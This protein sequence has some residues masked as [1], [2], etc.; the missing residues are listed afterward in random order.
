MNHYLNKDSGFGVSQRMEKARLLRNQE[1]QLTNTLKQFN[2]VRAVKVHLAIPRESSFIKNRRKPSASVLLNLYSRGS[3]SEEQ[4]DAMVDLVSGSIPNLN[5]NKVTIT[6][7]YGRLYHSGSMSQTQR[8]SSKELEVI[9]E[10]REDIK[11]RIEEILMPIV[12]LGAYTVQVNVD[13]DFTKTEQTLQTFNPDLPAVRSERTIDDNRTNGQAS[14]IPGALS[15]QPPGDATIPTDAT[16]ATGDNANQNN[17]A[18]NRRVEAE[19]N[20]DLDT[21]ISHIM[22]QVGVVKRISV[23]VGLDYIDDVNNAGQK[24]ARAQTELAR[25][26][27]LIQAAV[28]FT[29]QRGDIVSVESFPFI[30]GET[31]PEPEPLPFYEQ[32]LFQTWFKPFLGLIAFL[33]LIF[34]VLRPTMKKLSTVHVAQTPLNAEA[35]DELDL[36]GLQNASNELDDSVVLSGHDSLELPPPSVGEVKK[37]E[38]AKG[39]V[40]NNPTLVAQLVKSWIDEDG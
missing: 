7:Q 34:A 15:N 16:A 18:S 26:Q 2:G 11:S 10:R 31:L 9:R 40:G 32:E 27:N 39:V 6:D 37:L 12:G 19:R 20:F 1:L 23:S 13:M 22:P 30:Q 24:I 29:A 5:R 28:G 21:T 8:Q 36:S 14:G 25:I 3:L 33:I 38:Q 4:V 35:S 17:V